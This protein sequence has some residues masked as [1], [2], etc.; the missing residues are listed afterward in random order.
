MGAATA[1]G[2]IYVLAGGDVPGGGATAL[3]EA[4]AE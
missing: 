4:F 1:G 3:N 2:A